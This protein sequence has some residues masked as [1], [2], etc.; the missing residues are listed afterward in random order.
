MSDAR[1][2]KIAPHIQKYRFFCSML[3]SPHVLPSWAIF[4][5]FVKGPTDVPGPP[6]W[7][8]GLAVQKN[9]FFTAPENSCPYRQSFIFQ[10]L[11]EAPEKCRRAGGEAV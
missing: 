7:G 10:K 1:P 5:F 2:K 4:V 8:D 9:L 6:R 11:T 3:F